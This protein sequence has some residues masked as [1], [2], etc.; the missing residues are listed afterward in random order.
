MAHPLS[1]YN[2]A[3]AV[4][5]PSIAARKCT[6]DMLVF[7][8]YWKPPQGHT[9]V[10]RAFDNLMNITADHARFDAWFSVLEATLDG[11]GKMGSLVGASDEIKTLRGKEAQLAM[12]AANDLSVFAGGENALNEYAVCS[13]RPFSSVFY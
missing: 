5:S 1:I 3:L 9:F 7:L 13:E 12:Q 11:R 10:V 8:T 6:L 4:V 2:I